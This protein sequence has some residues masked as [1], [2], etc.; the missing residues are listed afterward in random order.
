MIK[1]LNESNRN[2][3]KIVKEVMAHSESPAKS[4]QFDKPLFH[5]VQSPIKNEV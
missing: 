4:H 1:N 3:I 2:L 5:R